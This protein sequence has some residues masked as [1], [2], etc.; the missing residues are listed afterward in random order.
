MDSG[1]DMSTRE[2]V[3]DLVVIPLANEPGACW[4]YG[5]CCEVL[6]GI[7]EVVS[8]CSLGEFYRQKI[9]KP[10]GMID[11]AFYA[12]SEKRTL[13]AVLYRQEMDD[14]QCRLAPDEE[15]H[16]VLGNFL[17]PP[18]FESAGAGLVST[19]RAYL[20]FAQML[21]GG[22]ELGGVRIIS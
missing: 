19:Y 9:F 16:L 13:L 11:T 5:L 14:Y 7:I 3:R 22:G 15:H 18:A 8:G 6:S 2:V 12:P 10:L 1:K 21:A 20:R 17:E 4:R